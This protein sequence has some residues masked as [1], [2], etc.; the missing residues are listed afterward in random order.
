MPSLTDRI[1]NFT[2]QPL[3][4]GWHHNCNYYYRTRIKSTWAASPHVSVY[5]LTRV[6]ALY[7]YVYFHFSNNISFTKCT[8][9][10]YY[11]NYIIYDI[12]TGISRYNIWAEWNKMCRFNRWKLVSFHFGFIFSP[13]H[14]KIVYFSSYTSLVLL[15]ESR[16]TAW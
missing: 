10:L 1:F 7:T 12:L 14:F 6:I 2:A 4:D 15:M 11:Y 8:N 3:L 16:V 13:F 5:R 9:G